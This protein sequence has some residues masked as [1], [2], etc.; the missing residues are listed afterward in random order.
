MSAMSPWRPRKS[1]NRSS[2]SQ[3][4]P[5]ARR[6]SPARPATKPRRSSARWN[7]LSPPWVKSTMSAISF[8]T[9]RRKPTFWRSMRRSRRRAPAKPDRGFAVVAQEVK[10]L[11]GQTEKAT[12]DITRQISSIEVTTSHVV[13]AMKAIAGTIAQL[14]EN[15]N[16]HFGRGA[17]A[18]RGQQGDRPQRQCRGRAHAR[19]IGRASRRS[20]MPRPRPARWQTPCSMPAASLRRVP[21]SCAPRSS[22]FWRRFASRNR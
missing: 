10:S 2:R 18:G 11:A 3:I 1:R 9:S 6:T 22:A 12:G 20:P 7:S 19:R 15:A 4:R 21:A 8:A 5:R 13:Q 17:A 14:D 16:G